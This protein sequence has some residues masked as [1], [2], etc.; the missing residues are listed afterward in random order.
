MHRNFHLPTVADPPSAFRPSDL[1]LADAPSAYWAAIT[2]GPR[3]LPAGRRAIAIWRHSDVSELLRSG[4]R[5][6]P[7]RALAKIPEGPFRD[8]NAAIMA[9]LDPPG[10]GPVRRATARAFAPAMLMRLKPRIEALSAKLLD[11]LPQAADMV[12]DYAEQLSVAVIADILGVDTANISRLRTAAH[13]VVA[14]LEPDANEASLL[15]ADAA[16]IELSGLLTPQL[17]DPHPNGVFAALAKSD[18]PFEIRLQNAIFLLNAGHETTTRLIAGVA[19][20]LIEQPHLPPVAELVEE[21][22]RLDPPLPFI[23]RF[24]EAPWNGLSEDT[25]VF[26]LLAAA[27]RD[28]RQFANPDRF[29][30]MRANAASHLSFAAGR[31][32]CLG[33]TLARMEGLIA[34]QHLS[35]RASHLRLTSGAKRTSGRMF[36]GWALL[37]VTSIRE[38]AA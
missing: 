5:K 3:L 30:P 10:H 38:S 28:P 24:L 25:P 36:Q 14:G 26:L 19:K 8:H 31:H 6:S 2:G 34:A 1:A 12:T 32:L 22:L 20:V 7:D 4:T 15:A 27:N 23:P 21:V 9:F 11:G 18:L 37:P 17:K 33:A 16:I 13:A 35:E 29:D